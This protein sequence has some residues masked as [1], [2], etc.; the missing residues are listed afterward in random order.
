MCS[1]TA[2]IKYHVPANTALAIAEKEGGEPGMT[3]PNKT[4]PMT[5]I[6]CS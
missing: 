6:R 3:L 2:A 4:A 1:I 5:L